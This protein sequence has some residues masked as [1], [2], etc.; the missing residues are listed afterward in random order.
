[1]TWTRNVDDVER[2]RELLSKNLSTQSFLPQ[3]FPEHRNMLSIMLESKQA[4]FN[5][6]ETLQF[7]HKLERNL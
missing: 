1:M 7:L 4:L 3:V 2:L 5:E 6:N